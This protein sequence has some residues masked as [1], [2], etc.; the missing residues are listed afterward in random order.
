MRVGVLNTWLADRYLP[1]WEAYLRHLEVEVVRPQLPSIPVSIVEQ[2]IAEASSLKV[3]G[4]DFLLLP[5]IQLGVE[6]TRGSPSPWMVSLEASLRQAIPGL[7]PAIVVP[8]ELSEGVA[9]LAASVGQTLTRN[10]MT[11]RRALERTRSLLTS[12]YKAP[13]QPSTHLVGV[14]AQPFVL[15]ALALKELALGLEAQGLHLFRADKSP[16][17]LRLEGDKLQLGLEL[18]TDLEAA[19]MHRYLARLGKV[20]GILYLHDAEVAP[21]PNPLRKLVSRG[22]PNKPWVLAGSSG[23]WEGVIANLTAQL[24]V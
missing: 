1:F 21:L 23:P 18:P 8:A 11:A 5:D 15:E 22:G 13:P 2:V 19:G 12:E 10:P 24:H 9:G 17:E 20:R 6:P 3:Q 16:Q 14:V 4:V 7:P